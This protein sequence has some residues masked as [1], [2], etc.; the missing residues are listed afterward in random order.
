MET[1]P[2]P[3]DTAYRTMAK[4]SL[5]EA[6]SHLRAALFQVTIAI[7]SEDADELP[8]AVLGIDG[9]RNCCDDAAAALKISGN[10]LMNVQ[11]P[12]AVIG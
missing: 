9:A 3:S 6:Q 1:R 11:R 10:L 2:S 12:V 8:S 7:E 5:V 4:T